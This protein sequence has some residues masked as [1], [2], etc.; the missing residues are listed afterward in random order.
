M[1][2]DAK[3]KTPTGPPD[4]RPGTAA[5]AFNQLFAPEPL[6]I[7]ALLVHTRVQHQSEVLQVCNQSR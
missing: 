5:S 7:S 1:W 3:K 6:P 2:F 4:C